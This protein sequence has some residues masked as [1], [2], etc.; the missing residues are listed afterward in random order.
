MSIFHAITTRYFHP[1]LDFR[2]R[3]F[4]VLAAAGAAVSA[5]VGLV[6]IFAG[7]GPVAVAIDFAGALLSFAL[8]HYSSH[9]GN[10]RPCFMITI[11]AVFL[12]L[13][14]YLF[15]S[16]GGYY[17]GIS[18]FFIF[19]VVF[20]V[21]M[22]QGG[23]A[24][25]FAG[26]ELAVYTGICLYAYLH[27]ASVRPLEGDRAL[28]ISVVMDFLVVSIALGLAMFV[29]MRMY[30]AQQKKIDEQNE[31][32]L[33]MNK[34]KSELLANTAHEMKTPLTV[35]SVHV[36]RA[37]RL[38]ELAPDGSKAKIKESHTLAQEEIMR[39]SR[40]VNSALN[41]ASMQESQGRRELLQP[42]KLLQNGAEVYRNLLE[43][44][45]NELLVAIEQPLPS[46][47]AD[48]DAIIQLLTNLISNANTHTRNGRISVRAR[49]EGDAIR[50]EVG[51]TGEGIPPE[52]LGGIFE[53]GATAGGSGSPS[54]TGLGLS[55][56]K[57]IVEDHGGEIDIESRPGEGT[58]VSFRLPAD[59]GAK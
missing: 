47:V 24:L 35:I 50:V 52:K 23:A 39:L 1:A 29:Q 27:P 10:Y 16:M 43:R 22:L 33:S 4:N 13:F 11:A 6:N 38:Y 19:A 55:I 37:Q 45:G 2:A 12:G 14:P 17:G 56:C 21:F 7:A 28:L 51:D 26:L 31:L 44:S 9:T 5:V 8:L 58:T 46:L 59:G 48:A 54:G 41:L 18:S 32:L 40:L 42:E 53:R 49:R 36:Q 25:A 15:F 30:L 20:T 57:R 34:A 3:L